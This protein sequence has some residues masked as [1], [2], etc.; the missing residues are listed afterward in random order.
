MLP[1][2]C[3][4]QGY[5]LQA[6]SKAIFALS[7]RKRKLYD[8]IMPVPKY[9][10][11]QYLLATPGMADPRFDRSIVALCAHDENGALGIN[12]GEFAEEFTFHNI[13][14]QFDIPTDHVPDRRVHIGGP[15]ELQRGFILHSLDMNL[16]D[17]LQVGHR[18]G[19]SSSV[20]MMRAIAE[21]DGPQNWTMALGYS[22]WGEG[23]LE[24]ELTQNGWSVV[25]G[26]GDWPFLEDHTD[27]WQN[28]WKFEGVDI[29]KLSGQFGSA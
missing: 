1:I 3:W 27:K 22:G 11:G 29:A 19:L 24:S 7:Y 12:L 6:I 25:L 2:A 17:T 21:G 4:W 18:W 14:E 16:S 15:V 8:Y 10:S 28:A 23:Q 26:D 13:L 5:E 20:D 9:L